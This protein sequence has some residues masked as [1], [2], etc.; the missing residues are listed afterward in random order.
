[1]KNNA[2]VQVSDTSTMRSICQSEG[3][4]LGNSNPQV[5]PVIFH[6]M[7][8]IMDNLGGGRFVNLGGGGAGH[9]QKQ[10]MS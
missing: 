1:M 9:P 10:A 3:P 4:P 5:D 8:T 7:K 2:S 6:R